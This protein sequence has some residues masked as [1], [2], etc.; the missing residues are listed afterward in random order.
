MLNSRSVLRNNVTSYDLTRGVW[1]LFGV[2]FVVF[3]IVLAPGIE[4]IM[5]SS[6]S[7][8]SKQFMYI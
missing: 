2:E 8:V 5:V 1:D 6:H 7:I 3:F 4:E